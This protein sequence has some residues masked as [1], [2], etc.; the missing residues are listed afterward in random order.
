MT[1]KFLNGIMVL[2]FPDGV[3]KNTVNNESV[4]DSFI[5]LF[6]SNI[7]MVSGMFYL[8][9][10]F[11]LPELI[12]P[13]GTMGLIIVAMYFATILL[14]AALSW[15]FNWIYSLAIERRGGPVSSNFVGNFLC[16]LYIMPMW[17][18]MVL[19]YSY[20]NDKIMSV[21]WV[22]FIVLFMIRLFDI[23]ARLLK[24]IYKLR[25]IQGYTIVFLQLLLIGIG[26][27]LGS[28]IE[29]FVSLP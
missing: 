24:I 6:V 2:V 8:F 27:G 20:F 16:H 5:A 22:L 10:K 12:I 17:I 13:L 25:L 1:T 11:K 4:I 28:L 9:K 18:F 21:G 29:S 7:I 23:E 19:L 26:M 14:T 3:F 15:F